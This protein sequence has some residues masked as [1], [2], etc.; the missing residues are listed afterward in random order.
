MM[1]WD[2]DHEATKRTKRFMAER[3]RPFESPSSITAERSFIENRFVL[4]VAS[5]SIA[6]GGRV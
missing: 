5:W 4:F 6:L 1:K 3:C 2:L